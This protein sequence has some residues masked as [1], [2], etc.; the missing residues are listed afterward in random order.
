MPVNEGEEP[1]VPLADLGEDEPPQP[2]PGEYLA[3][4]PAALKRPRDDEDKPQSPASL[5]GEDGEALPTFDARYRDDFEGLM[6]LGALTHGFSWLGHQ[7]VVRTLGEDD[8]MAIAQIVKPWQ[9]TI[10]ES[11][12]YATAYAALAVVSVDGQSLPS[13]V[14]DGQGEYAWAY[15]RY[16]YAKG[17]WFSP[18]IDKIYSEARA[19]DEK[20]YQVVVAMEKASGPVGASTLGSNADS[21]GP[22]DKGF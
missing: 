17:H 19:L 10:A 9:G 2:G 15:Q 6:F 4:D 16:Q 5:Y 3:Y 12:S 7:F 11:R 13:P 21:A 1:E 8:L 20:A 18:T 14:G 22:N